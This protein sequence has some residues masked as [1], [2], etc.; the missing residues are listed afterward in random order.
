MMAV[1]GLGWVG[2]GWVGLGRPCV[3][4]TT[5]NGFSPHRCHPPPPPATATQPRRLQPFL[6]LRIPRTA[7]QIDKDSS[8]KIDK[9]ELKE[10]FDNLHLP[11]AD[12]DVQRAL[13]SIKKDDD[14]QVNFATAMVRGRSCL[15]C[16]WHCTWR[17][18]HR[19]CFLLRR[20]SF[21]LTAAVTQH[22]VANR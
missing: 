12:E 21:V 2:L 9:S 15:H 18:D 22:F 17:P 16:I 13:N 1:V 6:T 7:H 3:A 11:S 20:C 4:F 14:E 5:V 8:G 10:L 19:W